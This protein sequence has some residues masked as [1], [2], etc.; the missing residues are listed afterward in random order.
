MAKIR[1]IKP[2]FW[3]SEQIMACSRDARLL[4]IGLWN[5]CDDAGIHPASYKT[6]KAKV[7]PS[8]D[9]SEDYIKSLV[10]SLIQNNLIESY[11]VDNKSYWRVIAW[12]KHQRVNRPHYKYPV[13]HGCDIVE[14]SSEHCSSTVSTLLEPCSDTDQTVIEPGSNNPGIGIGIGIGNIYGAQSAST[15]EQVVQEIETQGQKDTEIE[16][17]FTYWARIMSKRNPKLDAKRR[18][19]IGFALK[20]YSLQQLKQAIDGCAKSSYHMGNND[21]KKRYDGID[22]IFRDAE[23]I[24]KFIEIDQI[25]QTPVGMSVK[26]SMLSQENADFFLGV[27]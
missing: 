3:A 5:F 27:I 12:K 19:T 8:D 26:S 15:Q 6:L 10:D 21:Q 22:L 4:F 16:E 7:F 13:K 11:R 2:E 17:V 9:L 18:K 25:G 20:N 1:S 24:E 14:T 23:H